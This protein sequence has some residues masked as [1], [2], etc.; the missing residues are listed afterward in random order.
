[1]SALI[2]STPRRE[3]SILI[4]Q[5]GEVDE[6]FRS[7]M[8]LKAIKHLYPEV[9]L[10]FAARKEASAPLK[11]VDWLTSIIETPA[12]K[13]GEDPV[14]RVATWI[15]QVI[16]QHYDILANWTFADRYARMAGLATSLI[17]AMVKLGDYIREDMA[18]GSYDAWSM[19]RRAWLKS[20]TTQDIHHTDIITTQ[21][22]TALQIHAGDPSP[23]AGFTA[24]TSRYFFK[25]TSTQLPAAWLDRPKNLKWVAIH[26]PSIGDRGQEWVEMTLR[27]HPDAGIVILGE[28]PCDWE[29]E[30]SPRVVNLAGDLHFDSLIQILSQSNW[31]MSGAN[32]IVDLA[33]LI[34][35][36]VLFCIEPAVQADSLK[37]TENG[38]YGNG[39]VVIVSEFAPEVAYAAW[40]YY[41]SEWFHKGSMSIQNHFE[42][43]SMQSALEATQIY[44]SRIRPAQEGGGVCFERVD[45]D[46]QT[47]ES[48]MYRV[49]GQLARAWFCGWLPSVEAEVSKVK[50]NPNLIKRVREIKESLAVL[51][52]LSIEG[53]TTAKELKNSAE[54]LKNQRLMSVDDRNS[55]DDYAQKLLEVEKLMDRVVQVEPELRALV[56]WYQQMMHNLSGATISQMA[57]ETAHTFDLLNEGVE[58]IS[59]YAQK[60]IDL[61]RPRAVAPA[62]GVP[63]P[64]V[65]Q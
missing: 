33:S 17:P 30:E 53:Q 57:K 8:A 22:L 48:W 32:A 34:N 51:D 35:L 16:N 3:L 42:N 25:H 7:L 61:A 5:M 27:R 40:S 38:P 4:V 29:V 28:S 58:L 10:H 64:D 23:D 12:V 54:A 13:K 36:R 37:W 18:L 14:A 62:I 9:K 19:Y 63:S 41:S 15:D 6:V 50:L 26:A 2:D 31:L 56:Q 43:L 46:I 52:R 45:S 39:H 11:R 20:E 65:I 60:T 55:I 49:R 21:L 44:K 47:F 24:V 1:M 59:I